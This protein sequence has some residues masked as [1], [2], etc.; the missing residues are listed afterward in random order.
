MVCAATGGSGFLATYIPNNSECSAAR[1]WINCINSAAALPS[2]KALCVLAQLAFCVL[3]LALDCRAPPPRL[4]KRPLPLWRPTAG[5]LKLL[6][7]GAFGFYG[8]ATLFLSATTTRSCAAPLAAVCADLEV[9]CGALNT[10]CVGEGNLALS[11]DPWANWGPANDPWHGTCATPSTTPADP[12][13]VPQVWGPARWVAAQAGALPAP[14]KTALNCSHCDPCSSNEA[15]IY[16]QSCPPWLLM[17]L[18]STYYGFKP[19]FRWPCMMVDGIWFEFA[20][21]LCIALAFFLPGLALTFCVR[22]HTYFP[23]SISNQLYEYRF[24]TPL[25]A[26]CPRSFKPR[27]KWALGLLQVPIGIGLAIEMNKEFTAASITECDGDRTGYEGLLH[28]TGM[29][30]FTNFWP[31]IICFLTAFAVLSECYFLVVCRCKW[32]A[33]IALLPPFCCGDSYDTG[34]ETPGMCCIPKGAYFRLYR[35][36]HKW[37]SKGVHEVL[38]IVVPGLRRLETCVLEDVLGLGKKEAGKSEQAGAP[39]APAAGGGQTI[40]CPN[41]GTAKNPTT[42]GGLCPSCGA[43]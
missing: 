5:R 25:E 28:D 16:S 39:L 42:Q 36:L 23:G 24:G 14:P 15:A 26:Q 13:P 33:Y 32:F 34:P 43:A 12:S 40:F 11:D 1:L 3:L 17:P 37:S 7:F 9:A 29:L 21:G 31:F 35:W 27:H 10:M 20:I 18:A 4:T 6:A 8:S 41:C 30:L 22:A 19:R 38:L 2:T